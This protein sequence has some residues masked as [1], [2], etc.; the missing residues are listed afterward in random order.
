MKNENCIFCKLV[1]GDI[2]TD[3]VYEDDYLRAIMDVSPAN[4]G[5][6]IILPK[7]HAV[8]IF[9][10]EDEYIEKA[11]VLAKKIAIALKKLLGCDGVNILQNNEEAAGQTVFHFHVHI[12]PRY[13]ND[14]CKITWIQGSYKEGEASEIASKINSLI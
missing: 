14:S 1:N 8:N 12:I 3:T 5:H 2:P 11:F 9:E 6:V 13:N 7:S 4:K 10:L